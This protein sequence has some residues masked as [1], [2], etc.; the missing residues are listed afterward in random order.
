[1]RGAKRTFVGIFDH[2]GQYFLMTCSGALYTLEDLNDD[3][4]LE[5]HETG[6]DTV[7]GNRTLVYDKTLL[8]PV[9]LRRVFKPL[10]G[11]LQVLA[12]TII[13]CPGAPTR[14]QIF[15]CDS[16]FTYQHALDGSDV[17][18]E[19]V[20]RVKLPK[21]FDV[22]KKIVNLE[23]YILLVTEAGKLYRYCAFTKTVVLMRRAQCSLEDVL[24]LENDLDAAVEL[25][26]LER[27]DN[28][29]ILKIVNFPEMKVNYELPLSEHC[30]LVAQ[31]KSSM[32]MYYMEG[33][34]DDDEDD[35]EDDNG[36]KRR[37]KKLS[38][39]P[40]AVELKQITE[41]DPM[42]RF[43][44][45]VYR[46]LIDE[47]ELFAKEM[48]LS[49]EVIHEHRVHAFVIRIANERNSEA[50]ARTFS[51]FMQLLESVHSV[52]LLASQRLMDIPDRGLKERFL[53]FLRD[54]L[55][56]RD[57]TVKLENESTIMAEI[58]EQLNRLDTL[59]IIDAYS[60]DWHNF[61]HELNLVKCCL[62]MLKTSEQDASLI[63][64]R[65]S[66]AIVPFISAQ[67]LPKVLASLPKDAQLIDILHWLRHITPSLVQ[68]HSTFM[69]MAVRWCVEKTKSLE[70]SSM[71]PANGLQFMKDVHSIFS[72]R[73]SIVT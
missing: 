29:R 36:L 9:S 27:K 32:N 30:W 44:K 61:T 4:N 23:N 64:S 11:K 41:L 46:G 50:L 17:T 68:V 54:K 1:M 18:P 5:Q 55:L 59:K 6:N 8:S 60:L 19:Q 35:D 26:V 3:L 58:E 34:V 73:V 15:Y 37:K 28:E 67:D 66:N 22:L 42:Q 70:C 65:H 33:M 49:L 12:Y 13:G 53:I 57:T 63:W 16:S 38:P 45:L 51:D 47:A 62:Q 40:N 7:A 14:R 10:F 48:N 39:F 56:R 52:Q 72:A 21:S 31:P 2:Y 24:V 69:A 71:W 25:M 43:K 20:V